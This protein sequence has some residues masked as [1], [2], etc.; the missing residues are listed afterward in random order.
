MGSS[1]RNLALALVVF[2]FISFVATLPAAHADSVLPS[3][4]IQLEPD[5]YDQYFV[6][7]QKG[8]RF[9]GNFTVTDLLSYRVNN[10]L[11]IALNY[12]GIHTFGVEIFAF[13]EPTKQSVF[14]F[15]NVKADTTYFFNYTADYSG[16]CVIDFFCSM[17]VFGPDVEIPKVNFNYNVIEATPLKLQILSPL[18]QTYAE[19][20]LSLSF[21]INRMVNALSYSLDGKDNITLNG[22]ATI[23]RL[24]GGMHHITVY[25]N[26]TFGYT[27]KQTVT[28]TIEE[29]FPNSLV[30]GASG[31]SAAVAAVGLLVYFKKR[32]RQHQISAQS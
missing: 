13:V 26:D 2:F 27:D 1:R 18:N 28:F 3:G 16:T 4:T 11:A 21:T 7:L 25:A 6:E 23:T 31:T 14:N 24:S 20:N 10:P 17:N 19:S 12:S 9:E 8:D 5:S 15:R 30:I 29:P 22:N 32:K